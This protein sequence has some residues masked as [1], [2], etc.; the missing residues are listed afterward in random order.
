MF[1]PLKDNLPRHGFPLIT[2]VLI[3]LNCFI[4]FV[5]SSEPE[6]NAHVSNAYG[7]VAYE[8]THPGEQCFSDEQGT[9]CGTTE[10]MRERFPDSDFPPTWQTILTSM[11]LHADWMHLIGNMLF[12]LVFGMA[13]EAALGRFAFSG[14]Y[15]LGG[16]A[17]VLL[18]A[19]WDTSSPVPMVGASGAISALLAGYLVLFPRARIV[20]LLFGFFPVR[21]AAYWVIGTWLVTQLL[22]AWFAAG[23]GDFGGVAVFAHLGGFALGVPLTFLLVDGQTISECRKEAILAGIPKIDPNGRFFTSEQQRMQYYGMPQPQNPYLQPTQYAQSGQ[24]VDPTKP[25][26][27]KR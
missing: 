15:L 19:V 25:R 2:A 17:A 11:F 21:V 10:E 27:V 23:S 12:L 9:T 24:W 5:A 16:A 26:F 3:A 18:Q 20:S 7:V 14:F 1:V 13:L 22:M 8:L 6:S 4:F